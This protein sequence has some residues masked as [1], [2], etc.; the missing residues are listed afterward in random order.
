M[1]IS[2]LF[3]TQ[4]RFLRSTHLERD[5]TDTSSLQGYV[6]TDQNKLS[7]QRI[8]GG[9]YPQSGQRAW[10]I[11][12]DYG[13]GKSSFGLLLAHLFAGKRASL[14]SHLRDA[15]DFETIGVPNPQLV[16]ILVTGSREPI[17]VALLRS[18]NTSLRDICRRG[19]IPAILYKVEAT[20]GTTA[21]SPVADETVLELVTEANSYIR[22]SA[23]GS[24]SIIIL[25]ELGKFLEF[26]ALHPDEQDVFFLQ[27]LAETASRSIKEPLFVIGLLHQGFNA[28][29]D[30]LSQSA[31]KEW[32]KVAGRF[33]ELLFNQPLD[34]VAHLVAHALNIRLDLL[35][36]GI[37]SQARRDMHAVH[38]MGWYGAVASHTA[39][40]EHAPK[41]YPLH[42][43]V[44]PVLVRLFRRFGQNERS[45]FSFLLSN[46]PFGLRAF[47]EKH[48]DTGLFYRIHD[49]YDYARTTFGHRLSVQSYRSHW[50]YIDSVIESFPIDD[51]IG[52][53]ILK[54]VGLLNLLDHNNLLAS[55]DAIVL[56][57][58]GSSAV[59]EQ[60]VRTVIRDLQKGKRV[61]YSRGAA[62]GYCLWPHTS[63]NLDTAYENAERALG[64]LNRIAGLIQNYLETRPLVARRHYIETGNLRHFEVR[65]CAVADL[66][67][68]VLFRHETSD[69]L[70]LVPLGETEEESQAAMQFA[71]SPILAERQEILFAVPRRLS[72]LGPLVLEVKRWEWIAENT[73][74]LNHDPYAA[75][76][77]SRQIRASRQML[78]KRIQSVV[79]LQQFSG[80]TELQWYHQ[81]QQLD[82]RNSTELLSYLSSVC[83]E[84]YDMAPRILNEL[85]NRR[86][87]SSAAAAARMRLIERI[88]EHPNEPLIGMEQ[89]KKPPEMAMYLSVLQ[90]GGLHQKLN[91][92]YAFVEPGQE[93]DICR[94]RPALGQ[95]RQ[96]LE[97]QDSKRVNVAEIFVALRQPPFGVRDGLIPLLL[98]VF[99]VI[100]EQDIAFYEDDRFLRHITGFDFQRLIKAPETFEVQYCRRTDV[101]TDLFSKLLEVVTSETLTTGEAAVL[102]VVRP[103][104]EFAAQLPAYTHS[105]RRLNSI[106]QA[107]RTAVLNTREPATLLLHQLPEACG[108]PSFIADDTKESE[109]VH[110]FITVLR[111]ALDDLRAAYPEL[112]SR[113]KETLVKSFGVAGTFQDVRDILA[114]RADSIL[115]TVTDL[116]LKAFCF[117]LSDSYLPEVDWLDSLGS[118]VCA[119]PPS[120]WND[121]D[122]IKFHQELPLLCE[123]FQHVESIVFKVQKSNREGTAMRIAITRADGVEISKV[124]YVSKSEEP[125]A[126]RLERQVNAL[127]QQHPQIGLTAAARVILKAL[128]GEQLAQE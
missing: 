48:V 12:G 98:A 56:A 29:A 27:K 21:E 120:K 4:T 82:I 2:D 85:I 14:P 105:T 118:F 116:R 72:S 112:Q 102:D 86:S 107:V 7:L 43:T 61:L 91:G 127:L 62:G 113:M 51:E 44:L 17:S 57:V 79:G 126:L 45:L 59:N 90:Q 30:Q 125:L 75:E 103:L 69:G 46:E 3:Q 38:S 89:A 76:E 63:V 74:E 119:K 106:T 58:S 22:E 80:R 95:I 10:R 53:E 25:D 87:L 104:T 123:Q 121:L 122:E 32:E 11:T 60:H 5:F 24:G 19:R 33:E 18:L 117:R 64:P 39:L 31:Q 67:S 23:K 78:E 54:T 66:P 83:D 128:S 42:P 50:K 28:Y 16:P 124:L 37:F 100:H 34:E 101:R 99:V 92:N 41:L 47:S 20:L 26:A 36:G 35:P 15:V 52:L 1:R 8:A 71:I 109:I 6:L 108:F 84:V 96:I 88:F 9:L 13:S 114:N 94:L 68:S 81:N 73:P 49:L 93:E 40:V 115:V 65:Y 55:E 110:G 111:G 70:I 97:E 77:V